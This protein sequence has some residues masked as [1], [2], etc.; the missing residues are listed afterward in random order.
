M[1]MR[2][3][4]RDTL[5]R[6]LR[7]DT[8]RVDPMVFA[9]A[10]R[11]RGVAGGC[12]VNGSIN[13]TTS[14]RPHRRCGVLSWEVRFS[15]LDSRPWVDCTISRTTCENREPAASHVCVIFRSRLRGTSK[16]L[17][18]GQDGSYLGLSKDEREP[19]ARVECE[20]DGGRAMA[21]EPT[22]PVRGVPTR[23]RLLQSVGGIRSMSWG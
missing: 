11:G 6:L 10:S 8:S 4:G 13:A 16:L 18:T 21:T 17:C 1:M 5:L 12:L 15:K 23:G 22:R 2:M 3:S 7:I 19:L 14:R 9:E 20:T